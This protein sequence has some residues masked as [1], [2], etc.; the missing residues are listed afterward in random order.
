M[1]GNRFHSVIAWHFMLM[2]I[3]DNLN[4]VYAIWT[5]LPDL[6]W[7]NL[8]L[9]YACGI[10]NWK[11]QVKYVWVVCTCLSIIGELINGIFVL[12]KKKMSTENVRGT[13]GN[14]KLT[15]V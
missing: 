7:V 5:F 9:H 3:C 13:C 10:F 2:M 15:K 6:G 8:N 14:L 11:Q 1:H 12:G 4:L